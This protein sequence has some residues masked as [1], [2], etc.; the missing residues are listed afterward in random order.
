MTKRKIAALAL[1]GVLAAGG[2]GAAYTKQQQAVK[3][4]SAIQTA[5][6]KRM[7]F[8]K[9]IASSGKT[10][11]V[12][13]VELKFQT[14]G[15]LTWVGVKE[16]DR[17]EA[18]QAIAQLDSREVQKNL[19]NELR[20]YVKQR[21][22]FDEMWRVTYKGVNNPQTALTDTVKRILEKNQWDL[23]KAVLDVELK[24][25]SLEYST[26]VTPIAGIVTRVDTPVAGINITPAT[27]VFEVVDPGSLVFEAS[28]DE[29]DAASLAVGKTATITLD[30]FPD[31]PFAGTISKIAFTAK[32]SSGGATVFPVEVAIAS[33]S[34][35][36]I[37]MNGDVVIKA[38]TQENIL[39]IP[40]EA[41][42]ENGSESYVYKKQGKTYTKTTV[43]L[44]SRSDGEVV[45]GSGLLEGDE[46]VVKGFDKLPK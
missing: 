20:D 42:R 36:R 7:T 21:N 41:L 5:V 25:L 18:Y 12:R 9:S 13:A 24:H 34:A 10:K 40:S 46:V 2:G 31:T 26:L 39:I 11:A 23:E 28:V 29:V 17:V 37:G 4:V 22:D 16:G 8:T 43:E 30:A 3:T 14:S 38:D 6:V 15:K 45:V 32:T 27:A 1:A 33:V 19:E 44:G 35:M